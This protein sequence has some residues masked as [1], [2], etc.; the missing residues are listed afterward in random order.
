MVSLSDFVFQTV[1]SVVEAMHPGQFRVL[2]VLRA[3][4]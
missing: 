1:L 3:S 4:A 2:G